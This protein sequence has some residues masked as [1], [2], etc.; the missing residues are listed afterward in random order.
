MRAL[1]WI[2]VSLLALVAVLVLGGLLLP[3]T[4]HLERSLVINAPAD[5][6]FDLVN[7][8]RHWKNWTVWNQRDPAMKVEYFGT[9]Q[10]V[11]AGWAWQS[12]TEGD[13]KMTFT[14]SEAPKRVAYDLYFPD[15]DSTSTGDLRF[16]AE[17]SATR[18]IWSMDA[19]M[20]ANPLWRWMGL[21][22]DRMAGPDFETGL[23]RLKALAEQ[24]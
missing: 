1:K 22:M 23:A 11:G 19:N 12:A 6:V 8:P 7:Q 15:F 16:V 9:E 4:A 13:G 18:V 14:A 2:I 17:G 24:G 5:K 20:G 21:M 10:G 3:R